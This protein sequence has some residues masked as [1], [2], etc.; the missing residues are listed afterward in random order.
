MVELENQKKELYSSFSSQKQK[1]ATDFEKNIFKIIQYSCN[2]PKNP[3]VKEGDIYQNFKS[4]NESLKNDEEVYDYLEPISENVE[5]FLL[6]N[7]NLKSKLMLNKILNKNQDNNQLEEYGNKILLSN[8]S[9]KVKVKSEL[10][11]D[12]YEEL[13]NITKSLNKQS[14]EIPVEDW[15]DEKQENFHFIINDI[16]LRLKKEVKELNI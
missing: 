11:E 13:N 1:I 8:G 14:F 4:F 2:F 3:S 16:K 6:D 9:F 15:S 12:F 5:N 7:V 10:L